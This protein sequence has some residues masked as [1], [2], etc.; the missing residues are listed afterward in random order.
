M[1]S[2]RDH[3]PRTSQRLPTSSAALVLP[4]HGRP[5]AHK[6]APACGST[7]TPMAQAGPSDIR[8]RYLLQ[9]RELTPTAASCGRTRLGPTFA[10]E[11]PDVPGA[12]RWGF[13]EGPL[14]RVDCECPSDQTS[15]AS[16]RNPPH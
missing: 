2:V 5:S 6:P 13:Q 11:F 14:T 3:N 8:V 15:P 1:R 10:D 12:R 7:G 16:A 4:A 9:I